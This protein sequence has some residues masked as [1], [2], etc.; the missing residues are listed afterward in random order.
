MGTA[1]VLRDTRCALIAPEE[2]EAFAAQVGQVL[3]SPELRA[4]LGAAGP[5]DAQRWSSQA[6]MRQVESLYASLA[7]DRAAL[8]AT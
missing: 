1:M 5:H 6:L 4:V 8:A 7:Q 3:R 2:V